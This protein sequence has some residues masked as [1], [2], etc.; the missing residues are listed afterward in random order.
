MKRHDSDIA[1]NL[2]SDYKLPDQ[3][4][5]QDFSGAPDVDEWNKNI[6]GKAFLSVDLMETKPWFIS[7]LQLQAS[8]MD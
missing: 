2:G 1:N 7:H 6:A 8:S 3:P 4:E 5:A